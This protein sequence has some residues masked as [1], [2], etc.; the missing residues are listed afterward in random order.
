MFIFVKSSDCLDVFP[1]NNP[2]S[3]KVKI[4]ERL[5]YIYYKKCCLIDLV[6]PMFIESN[7]EE[8]VYVVTNF[9]CD[10]IVGGGKLP[11]VGRYIQSTRLNKINI[12]L[13]T[14]YMNMKNI[15]TDVLEIK[16]INGKSLKLVNFESGV[17][18]C[19]FHFLHG[20]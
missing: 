10:S 7:L 4:P 9:V 18:Y 8:E 1:Q 13:G 16:I 3:F 12:G 6:M 20:V 14:H 5:K 17:L 15:D 11:V 19:T 2:S